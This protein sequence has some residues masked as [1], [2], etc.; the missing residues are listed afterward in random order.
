MTLNG[1]TDAVTYIVVIDELTLRLKDGMH[2]LVY[3]KEL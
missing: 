1:H 3:V 2:V